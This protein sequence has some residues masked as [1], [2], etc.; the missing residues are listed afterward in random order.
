MFTAAQTIGND[1]HR[2]IITVVAKRFRGQEVC[3]FHWTTLSLQSTKTSDVDVPDHSRHPAVPVPLPGCV[4]LAKRLW[5]RGS[6][7]HNM[8]FQHVMNID[9]DI[10]DV[11]VRQHR[12]VT[13]HG[14]CSRKIG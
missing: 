6:K 8:S 10:L 11:S 1:L 3:Q 2:Q 12:G 5:H 9:V 13:W 4:V 14:Q 7:L